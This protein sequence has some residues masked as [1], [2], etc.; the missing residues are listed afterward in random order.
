MKASAICSDFDIVD[1]RSAL[2]DL[3]EK[4]HAQ[5][6]IAV[7][8][9]AD[10]MYHY[11]EKVCLIQLAADSITAVVDPLKIG[12][13]A[14]LKPL[15]NARHIR[16][17]IHGADYDVRS[18]YRDFQITLRNLF[19]TQLASRFLGY[20]ETGLDA[21]LQQTFAISL[22]KRFQRKDWS[23]RPL[24]E[25]MLAYAAED[26]RH[27]IPL[28]RN[29]ETELE[30]KGRLSWVLE[31]CKLLSKVRPTANES[32]PLFLHFK[33]AGGLSVRSLA[34]LEAMLQYR[35]EVAQL[36]DRPLFRVISNTSLLQLAL[37]KPITVEQLKRTDVLSP[38]QV[39]LHGHRL[40]AAIQKALDLP[41]SRMRRYPHQK[42]PRVPSAAVARITALKKWRNRKAKQLNIDPSLICS[43]ALIS[44][45]AT[46]RPRHIED[47]RILPDMRSWQR[48][49][50]GTEILRVIKY[51]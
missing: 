51:A 30:E 31:E 11:K 47:L 12:D 4:L 44:T 5:A 39:A 16:K 15:F 35:K 29:M 42:P 41:Q 48:E 18:L 33:G 17:V 50:F 13:L 3:V 25:D 46:A 24:P 45:I 49:E 2:E 14:V 7:D 9:E 22:D 19:D 28:A 8:L 21:V 36:H 10:S 37:D 26:V 6:E 32:D 27:L 23:R 20:A 43:K 1:T 38:K 34:A 40:V